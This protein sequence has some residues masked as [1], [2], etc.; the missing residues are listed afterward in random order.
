MNDLPPHD[1]RAE[2]SVLGAMMLSAQ[3]I[4]D[5]AEVLCPQDFYHP[6][7][8]SIYEAAVEVQQAGEPVDA[9]TLAD[10]LGRRGALT[11]VGGAPYL[12]TL[13]QT[14][15]VA[16]SAGYYAGIV[17]E[18]ATL[19]RLIEAGMRVTQ[20]GYAGVDGAD[21]DEVVE[22]ARAELDKLTGNAG[23]G[24]TLELADMIP[25]ALDTLKQAKRPG[26]PTGFTDL[27]RIL[28]G[29]LHPG[30]FIV[31]GARPGVG[32]ALALD[33]PLPT[34]TGWTTMGEV[35]VGEQVLGMDG[36]PTTVVAATEVMHNRPCYEIEFSDG[37]TIVADA[38]HQ[39]LTETRSSRRAS[40]PPRGVEPPR[41]SSLARD[42]RFKSEKSS[43][44]AT[45]EIAKTQRVGSDKRPNHSIPVASSIQLPDRNLPFDPY[46]FGYWLG[47]GVSL[48]AELCV[49]QDD[50]KHALV[51]LRRAGLYSSPR[52]DNAGNWRVTF[53]NIPITTGGD[54]KR[55]TSTK[56]L[57]DMG[58]IQNKHIPLVYLRASERQRRELLAGLLDS[59]GTINKAGYVT[60][61][62]CDQLLAEG[63][64]ELVS[65][66]GMQ[67]RTST[68]TVRGRTEATSTCW[69]VCFRPTE[70]V[71]YLTRKGRRIKR[72]A[73]STS[74]R[75]YIAAV[76]EVE[77]VP[78]RCVQVNNADRMYLASR[79]FIPTHNSLLALRF[80]AQVAAQGHGALMVSLEMSR[81]ELMKRFF[82]AEASVELTALNSHRLSNDDWSR[83]STAAEKARD[84]PLAV[85]DAPRLGVT[86]IASRARD[87]VRTVRG[88]ALVVVDYVQLVQPSDPRVSREQQI[89]GISRGLKLLSRELQ[90]P[91]VAAAQV[92]RGSEQ[93]TGRK[94][95]MSD[96]RESGSLE[97]DAD[98]VLLLHDDDD[99]AKV[100]Q[101]EVIVAKNRHGPK[102]SVL[103][104]WAPYYA[105]ARNLARSV[106]EQPV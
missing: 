24:D 105:T 81:D 91:V 100:G 45:C 38:Q 94:P 67:V 70:Q 86:G 12:H 80:A 33:T 39:W 50:L 56:R 79:A 106:W 95:V 10:E 5:V 55:D 26:C 65:S 72:E 66:L 34:P 73:R 43:V 28:N 87:R 47:D 104:S 6:R 15:P 1:E 88:L 90:V 16:S 84:W 103:L 23:T 9:V 7:H 25:A 62:V 99:Q 53:S 76:R 71:F 85:T 4:A 89:A 60:F 37:T 68:K 78:V 8:Q 32:K 52:P 42:Q 40:M 35:T 31:I 69:S 58:V 30:N 18:K 82:A 102:G 14:V 27:D 22:R 21:V 19:R 57:R 98:T 64:Q 3:A 17:A 96:L 44:K 36:L 49:G 13:V 51:E 77:S 41:T 75:R 97:A 59:D 11:R 93:R 92:N 29:G 54:P 20:L 74:A 83:V 101:I 46:I 61:A 2:Q 63:L 48:R